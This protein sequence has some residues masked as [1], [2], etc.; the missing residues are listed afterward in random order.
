MLKIYLFFLALPALAS[1]GFY[2]TQERDCTPVD[3]RNE[4]LGPIRDQKEIAWCYA[5]TAADMLAHA[6][7]LRSPI[8]AADIAINYNQ[9]ALSKLSRWFNPGFT[10]SLS[11]EPR[12]TP[13]ETGFNKIALMREM[14]SGY[15]P[16]SVFSSEQW[17]KVQKADGAWVKSTV[18]MFE[19]IEN[20]SH[21]YAKR[22]NLTS[23]NVPFY[24]AFKNVD[25][26]TFVHLL[27]TSKNITRFYSALRE[28]ICSQDRTEFPYSLHARM[29]FRNPWIFERIGGVLESKSIV[30]L[31]Y[32][33]RILKDRKHRGILFSELHTSSI[34]GRR[35]NTQRN[36][37]EYL[38]RNS[39]GNQCDYDPS[40]GCEGGHV[41]IDESVIYPNMTSIVYLEDY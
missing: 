25:V 24:F 14:N 26:N 7:K 2:P 9:S 23:E 32:D 27:H 1:A 38:I 39:Y 20:I 31:D 35:W 10:S 28:K 41:W 12:F 21:L 40:Y 5:F 17:I 6:F 29:V 33:Y 22:S 3:V 15:C 36:K 8:S 37:C 11:E 19:A 16:E 13:Q 4:F 30:G 18:P 34:V